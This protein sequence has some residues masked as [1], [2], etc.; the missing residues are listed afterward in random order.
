LNIFGFIIIAAGVAGIS[1][2]TGL[3]LNVGVDSMSLENRE[4]SLNLGG[5][6]ETDKSGKGKSFHFYYKLL[7]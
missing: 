6:N 2:C 4:C 3:L 7:F 5:R 1:A